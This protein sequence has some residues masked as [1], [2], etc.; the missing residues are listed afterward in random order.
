MGNA[1]LKLFK[2]NGSKNAEVSPDIVKP[3]TVD[4]ND[5][6]EEIGRFLSGDRI[7]DERLITDYVYV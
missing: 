7:S 6:E 3:D 5:D 4:D 1:S 2:T